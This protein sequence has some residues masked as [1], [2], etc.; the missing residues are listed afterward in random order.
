MDSLL[1]TRY[2]APLEADR[3]AGVIVRYA[4][5]RLHNICTTVN[6]ELLYLTL[7]FEVVIEGGRRGGRSEVAWPKQR[8]DR[9]VE[10]LWGTDVGVDEL[11]GCHGNVLRRGHAAECK[12]VSAESDSGRRLEAGTTGCW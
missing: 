4:P 8:D 6:S 7:H 12:A 2:T 10:L 3:C 11:K 9:P 1:R 5:E